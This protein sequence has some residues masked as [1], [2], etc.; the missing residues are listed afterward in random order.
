MY[1]DSK[2]SSYHSTESFINEYNAQATSY[3]DHPM[4]LQLVCSIH[5]KSKFLN[6]EV[7]VLP[8]CFSEITE[9]LENYKINDVS[10]MKITLDI[11]RLNLPKE[12]MEIQSDLGFLQTTSFCSAS[13]IGSVGT[14]DDSN[15]CNDTQLSEQDNLPDELTHLP[16]YQHTAISN[17][18]KEIEWLLQ[19]ET[20]TALLDEPMPSEKTLMFVARHVSES[21]DRSSCRMDNVPLHFVFPS[22]DSTP[23]FL[24]ELK[25]LQ[26]DRYR[27]QQEKNLFYCVKDNDRD[28]AEMGEFRNMIHHFSR[29][30]ADLCKSFSHTGKTSVINQ[31]SRS[32]QYTSETLKKLD[33][34]T[35]GCHSEV[36]SIG[37]D[38]GGTEDG[39]EGDSSDSEDECHWLVD[40]DQRRKLLPNFWLILSVES[41]QVNVYFHCR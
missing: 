2:L 26:V 37:D 24:E 38:Q 35:S 34:D 7:K 13:S 30:K 1:R 36:S 3:K 32:Y 15:P 21:K 12:V 33:N 27:I 4:F 40:L 23:V 25:K 5:S 6:T 28:C 17:L 9:K 41:T 22:G 20:A 16:P 11:I 39:Y 31:E 18:V 29:I 10:D 14:A 19:D 8:T